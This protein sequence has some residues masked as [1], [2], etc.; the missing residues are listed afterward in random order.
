[1]GPGGDQ[2]GDHGSSVRDALTAVQREDRIPDAEVRGEGRSFLNVR[3]TLIAE[4]E[5]EA[6]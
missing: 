6:R 4:G 5:E 1:M 2:E 3:G